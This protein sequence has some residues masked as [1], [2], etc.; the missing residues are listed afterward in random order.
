M[1]REIERLTTLNGKLHTPACPNDQCENHSRPVNRFRDQYQ[2]YGKTPQGRSR[3]RCKSCR[4]TF[5]VGRDHRAFAQ[6]E[7]NKTI[8]RGLV[9]RLPI[10]GLCRVLDLNADTL[11][12]RIDFLH[13]QMVAFEATRL[14]KLTTLRK[15]ERAF[16]ALG[17]DAQ[18]QLVNWWA[19]DR[20]EPVQ[21]STITTADNLSGFVFRTDCNYDP[22]TG[23]AGAHFE[24][25]ATQGDFAVPGA[26]GLSARYELPS[27]ARAA[28]WCLERE[29]KSV[30]PQADPAR[31]AFLDQLIALAV[32]MAPANASATEPEGSPPTGVVVSREYTAIAH[33]LLL[34]RTFSPLA[35]MHVMTDIDHTLATGAM[36]A[37]GDRIRA[38]R[39]DLTMVGFEKGLKQPTK[40]RLV[41]QY[42][43]A[44][45]AFAQSAGLAGQDAKTI[46]R[47]FIDTHAAKENRG[48]PGLTADF[49][50]VPVETIYEPRKRV[51]IL[52]QRP[53]ETSG[54][55]RAHLVRLLDR[56][57]LHA[58]DTFF[59][60]TRSRVS[61]LDRPGAS[62]STS[63]HYN[64]FQPYRAE[65]LQ[66]VIDIAR[67]F[68]N[69]C[70]VR[71]FRVSADFANI[72][73][74]LAATAHQRLQASARQN[75][76]GPS[77]EAKSTPAMR[78]GLA[79][80]PVDIRTILY[81]RWL[82]P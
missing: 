72:E 79:T 69:W 11:Y 31:A 4:R 68:Y 75:A 1:A 39:V 57:S 10:R 59:N 40:E 55:D 2:A 32:Q 53:Q 62:R 36:V 82:D 26:L 38:E 54:E 63:T 5:A 41:A 47:A 14:R 45:Q 13:R 30:D 81:G 73:Q 29:H 76:R 44:L 50:R 15:Y 35:R 8:V 65:Q 64:K 60:H 22:G 23:D 19:R 77:R 25:L 42:Q 33:F 3:Y 21:I 34:D 71:P 48:V 37:M 80:R 49:W 6:L 7:A 67:V 12:R 74:A 43:S 51:G 9:N 56:S 20:R 78:L 28:L 66:K 18:D 58:T 16:F 52:H 27:F 24:W 61:Y 70:E 46:R 17:T